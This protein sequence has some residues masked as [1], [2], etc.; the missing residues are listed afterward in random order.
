MYAAVVVVLPNR[1]VVAATTGRTY[2]VSVVTNFFN[3]LT[4][5]SD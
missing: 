4:P 3:E 5:K 2:N 1:E